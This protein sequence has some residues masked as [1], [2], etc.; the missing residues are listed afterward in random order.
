MEWKL[1]DYLAQHD[2]TAHQLALESKLSVNS[3]YPVVRGKAERVS[4]A[5]LDK[6]LEALDRLTGEKVE[7]TDLLTREPE[8]AVAPNPKKGAWRKLRGA[9]NDPNSPGDIA[10]RHDYYLGE[11]LLEEHQEGIEGKR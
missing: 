3:V 4:L 2:I 9:L 11:A 8:R 1:K 5:T 6:M 10:E 7:L